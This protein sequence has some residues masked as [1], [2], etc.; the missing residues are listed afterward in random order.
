[1][2]VGLAFALLLAALYVPWAVGVLRFAPLP[3]HELAAACGLGL[4]SVVWF[5]GIKWV[6]RRGRPSG[7]PGKES[8]GG[9]QAEMKDGTAGPTP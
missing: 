4:L 8:L 7:P 2:V 6:R 3:A 9:S 5:E 1:V